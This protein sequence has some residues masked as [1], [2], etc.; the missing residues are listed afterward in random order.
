M[1]NLLA[2]LLLVPLTAGCDGVRTF[3]APPPEKADSAEVPGFPGVRSWGDEPSEASQARVELMRRF[4]AE[5]IADGVRLPNN[6]VVDVLLLSGGGSDG[7]YGAGLLNGWSARGGRPEFWVVTGISTGALIAP[8]AFAGPDF[9]DELERFYTNTRTDDLITLRL[10]DALRGRLLGLADR[11]LLAEVVEEA[12]TPEL[13]ARIAAE[14]K[15]GRRLLIGTT[16]LD[17]QRPVT[18]DIGRIAASGKPG[19]RQLIRDILLASAAIPGAMPPVQ[20][21]VEAEGQDF[22]EMHVDGGVTRQLFFLP[23]SL[24]LDS[25][26][27]LFGEKFRVGTIYLIRNT[28]LDPDYAETQAGIVPITS[29]SISTLIK[30]AGVADV[31]LIE[32]QARK[33]GFALKVTSVPPTFKHDENEMFDPVYM[34]ALYEV[35]YSAAAG[36]DPWKVIVEDGVAAR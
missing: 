21:R 16:N 23:P 31:G 12:M 33:N 14:H 35:G 9:D 34:R 8:F 4:L 28:K 32:Q 26:S 7:A 17:A 3:P 10:L 1:R 5:Q 36:G 24:R 22:S 11:S 6:G 2:L 13:M 15:R 29:R 20:L 30:F 19:A 25:I 18:W 27:S